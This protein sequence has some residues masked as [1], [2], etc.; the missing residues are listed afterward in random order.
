MGEIGVRVWVQASHSMLMAFKWLLQRF[1]RLSTRHGQ[2][3]VFCVSSSDISISRFSADI[4]RPKA[5]IVM[6]FSSPYNE[7]YSHVIKDACVDFN[8]D[9]VR[10]D[11][12]NPNVYFEVVM[13]WR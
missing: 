3:C 9:A 11:E 12:T 7:V 10:G 4:E 6:Q 5:F 13:L 2:I 1:P 8:I